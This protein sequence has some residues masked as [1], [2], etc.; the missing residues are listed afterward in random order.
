MQPEERLSLTAAVQ[1][2][3][4]VPPDQAA[5]VLDE[6]EPRTCRGGDW[7]F[8]Q[9]D[10]GDALYLLVRGLMQVWI[11]SG[12]PDDPGQR[13]VAE[14]MP[15]EIIGEVG[16]LAGGKRSAG[17]RAVR[18]SL[19]LRMDTGAFDRL[20]RQRPALIRQIAGGIAT[21]L[22][23]RTAG[24]SRV[25]HR[26]R[27]ITLLPLDS[28]PAARN[29]ADRLAGALTPADSTLVLSSDRLDALGAPQ[30][31]P[32]P[33][34]EI[35]HDML[36]WLAGTED[37]HRFLIYVAD[38]GN[39]A[40][41]HLALRHADLILVVG[42][43]ARDAA[44][45]PWERALFAAPS[46]PVARRALLL[47]HDGNPDSLTG[48][49]AWLDGRDLD[50]HLHLR[51][52]S[53]ADF[54]RLARVLSG[55]SL[56]LVLGGGAARGFAHI[57]V[58]RAL[59]EAGRPVDWLGG[60][61]IG[62]IMAAA[63]AIGGSP[64]RVIAIVRECFVGGKPFSDFTIPVLS[65]LRG[66]RMER[67]LARHAP[68]NIEDLPLPLFCL[69][70]NLGLG[71]LQLH[72][73][74][75]VALA[76][77][78]GASLPGVFPPAVVDGQL[79][80]DGGILDNLPVDEMLRRPVGQVVAV[81]LTAPRSF[82]VDYDF[83]PSPWAVLAGRLLPF[84]PRYRVPG[85]MSAMLKATEIGT[86]QKVAASGRRADLLIKPPVGRFGITDVRSFDRI[87]AAGYTHA[88]EV[89]AGWNPG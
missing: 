17:I 16:L 28:G 53:T 9:G 24:A 5:A 86:M 43:A 19:L 1:R 73:R 4:A 68:M 76:L 26:F 47:M 59:C 79:T 48:T 37:R 31:P 21:R 10:D 14:V 23:D 6:L 61:S 30:L 20:G 70:S 42:N 65:L 8:R 46:P 69:S 88:R 27:T 36:E 66:R 35:S 56:G 67:L 25:R 57:G 63:I 52:G 75:P 33:T 18:D 64:E 85:F 2:H 83:V 44:I 51:E 84:A 12:N 41:T 72:E 87:V 58:Y 55:T 3:F 60:A 82:D 78:A 50:F 15:G 54:E 7:L 74:G 29:L 77:R 39:T 89:L 34:A 49:A 80:I 13:L 62:A 11:D 32:E 22:R 40:W 38:P 71:R 45:R 81:D